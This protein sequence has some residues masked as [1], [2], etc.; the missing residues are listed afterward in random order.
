[1]DAPVSRA[2]SDASWNLLLRLDPDG[3]AALRIAGRR[4]AGPA[5]SGDPDWGT[6]PAVPMHRE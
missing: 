3:L 4:T 1:M 6:P 5:R 2:A